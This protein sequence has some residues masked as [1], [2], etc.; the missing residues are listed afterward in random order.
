M[1][2]DPCKPSLPLLAKTTATWGLFTATKFFFYHCH[3]DSHIS[4]FIFPATSIPF[5]HK[6]TADAGV[7]VVEVEPS[8]A[9]VLCLKLASLLLLRSLLLPTSL[10]LLPFLL[11]LGCHKLVS[12]CM[13]HG[14]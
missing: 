12:D 10:M 2:P 5:S 11:L 6:D 14:H 4:G 7:F 3:T 1:L 9:G 8:P 13:A